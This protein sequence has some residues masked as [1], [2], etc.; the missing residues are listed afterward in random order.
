MKVG[1]DLDKTLAIYHEWQG[2]D[3]IGPPIQPMLDMV[4]QMIA[5]GH[6]VV[7]FSRRAN[8]PTNVP[9]ISQWLDSH[10]LDCEIT[11]IKSRDM[12]YIF[13]DDAICVEANTGRI[14]CDPKGALKQLGIND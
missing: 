6:Q 5:N 11:A 4:R 7:I 10:G 8:D 9:F 14:L 13:D 1:V 2:P 12:E 3:V